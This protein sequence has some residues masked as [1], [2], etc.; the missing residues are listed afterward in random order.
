MN[1]DTIFALSSGHG[2][3]GVA[4]IRISGN[5]LHDTFSNFT[6]KSEFTNRHAYFCNLTDNNGD[7]LDQ[8]L[9][10]YFPAPNS[11]T[12]EDVIELHTH[13]A[14][15]TINA[16]FEH[17]KT[18]D[19]RMAAPGEFS[20]RAFYNNKMDLADV[21][22]LAALLDAQTEQ[23]RKHALKSMLGHDSEIYNTW[24]TQMVE[25]SAYAAAILDYSPD[26][27]PANIGE[28]VTA[29]TTKLYNEINTA[30]NNYRASRAIRGG[31]NIALVGE[32]NVG[33][34]SI[35]NYLAG[36]NRA[37][38]SDIAGTTRDVVSINL[39]IDGYLINLSDTAGLR[40]TD[41]VIE[42][43]GIE[44]TKSEIENADI[45]IHV[46]TPDSAGHINFADNE[47]IVINK[48]DTSDLRQH[49]NAIYTSTKTGDGM[50]ML[51]N[52]LR[53]KIHEIMD[54]AENAL[55]IN[56]RTHELLTLTRDELTAALGTGGN[57]DIFAE[58]TRR[59]ADSIGKILG[60]ITA[61]EVLDKTFGQLCL[62]K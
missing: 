10:I 22:G 30:L 55:T 54:G 26:D 15:A 32:T 18:L 20:R 43:I 4:V 60:T 35:F 53:K 38:V 62:G 51:L 5:N 11:F 29:R 44:R 3:S 46:Y 57:Y 14:P 47:I 41:D 9:A 13:G 34:S 48:S 25:I 8:C 23:Q 19:M 50:D 24:R 28:T 39:D 40:E 12:G 31:I 59:A 16:I 1:N 49:K 17:L 6:N 52:T 7:L 36:S 27:L 37:I 45:I 33:K 61:T 56:A 58:H 21:D 42:S 2:K